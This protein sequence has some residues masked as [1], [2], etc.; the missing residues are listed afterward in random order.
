M[1]EVLFK[2]K[3]INCVKLAQILQRMENVVITE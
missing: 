1:N 3:I 2:Y